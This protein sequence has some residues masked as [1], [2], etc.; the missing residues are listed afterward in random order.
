[1]NTT[2]I[3]AADGAR[4]R[5]FAMEGDKVRELDDLSN[6]HG[7]DAKR[8]INTDKDGRWHGGGTAAHKLSGSKYEPDVDPLKHEEEKFAKEIGEYLERASSEHRFDDLC[9]IAPPEFMGRLRDKMGE[10]AKKCIKEELVKDISWFSDAAVEQ[11]VKQ[12]L[13]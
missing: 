7:R 2:W 4:A 12:H 6:P 8:D 1:M 13:H 9:V 10:Q 11:Y 3:L 5:I